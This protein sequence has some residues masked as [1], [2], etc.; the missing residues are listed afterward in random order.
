MKLKKRIK[1]SISR[2]EL[3]MG[4]SV[5]GVIAWLVYESAPLP[6]T[7]EEMEELVIRYIQFNREAVPEEWRRILSPFMFD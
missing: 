6:R 5:S 7:P 4:A 2:E 1:H 3:N